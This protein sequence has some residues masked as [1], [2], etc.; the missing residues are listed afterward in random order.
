MSCRHWCKVSYVNA[1]TNILDRKGTGMVHMLGPGRGIFKLL[2]E[3][4]VT[5]QTHCLPTACCNQTLLTAQASCSLVYHLHGFYLLP[6]NITSQEI[7][8]VAKHPME[9]IHYLCTTFSHAKLKMEFF[10]TL[11]ESQMKEIQKLAQRPGTAC[12]EIIWF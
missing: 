8:K 3:P 9:G 1:G 12:T 2:K 6:C 5:T 4:I 10:Q 11:R 7:Q